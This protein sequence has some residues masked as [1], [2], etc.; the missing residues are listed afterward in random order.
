MLISTLA[1]GRG[2]KS[3]SEWLKGSVFLHELL[4]LDVLYVP[5]R[6]SGT[7]ASESCVVRFLLRSNLSPLLRLVLLPTGSGWRLTLWSVQKADRESWGMSGWV[8]EGGGEAREILSTTKLGPT[9][10]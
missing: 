5:N 1:S 9:C 6:S 10:S 3:L 2:P 8:G 7:Y 4:Q